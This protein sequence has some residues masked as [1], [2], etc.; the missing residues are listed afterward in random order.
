MLFKSDISMSFRKW[1]THDSG[2]FMPRLSLKQWYMEPGFAEVRLGPT[3][4]VLGSM[5][6]E[7]HVPCKAETVKSQADFGAAMSISGHQGRKYWRNREV[8]R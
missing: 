6:W 1:K 3:S 2:K 4:L 5:I 8:L 7:G